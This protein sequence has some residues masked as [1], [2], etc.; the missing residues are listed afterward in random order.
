[1]RGVRVGV[2]TLHLVENHTL[3]LEGLILQGN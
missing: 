2:D 3:V 1:M